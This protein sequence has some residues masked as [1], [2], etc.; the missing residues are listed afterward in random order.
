MAAPYKATPKPLAPTLEP[1]AHG[2]WL[3]RGGMPKRTMNVY[4][5]EDEDGV[6]I[7]DAGI[8]EMTG[9][10][11]DVAERMGGLRRVVLG[12]AHE[13]HRGAAPGL[14]APV[15]CHP[16]DVADAEGDGGRHR[17]DFTKMQSPVM[18]RAM[19]HLLSRWDGGP[20]SVAG[21]VSEGDEVAGFEV[22]HF[23]GHAAGLIGLWRED[24]RLALVS[25]TVYTLEV[26]SARTPFGPPRVPHPAFTPDRA[27]A[28][29]SVRKLAALEPREVWAG[30][31][32]PV[33]GDV[34]RQLERAADAVAPA[35]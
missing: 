25:D 21:T 6:T 15:Y 17:F 10:L 23:P 26:D 31:A 33:T 27:Q 32:N 3:M 8:E 20:V 34:V 19:P 29:D 35:G 13:D 18:R 24:D 5:L 11:R 1:V 14:G 30:H 4:L 12:H 9:P 7:F 22:K 16:D 28:A 2:V